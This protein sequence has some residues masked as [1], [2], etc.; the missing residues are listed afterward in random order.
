M[1]P[2]STAKV[3]FLGAGA[4]ISAGYP[5]TSELLQSILAD[6]SASPEVSSIGSLLGF[7]NP[8]IPLSYLDL[9]AHA[10]NEAPMHWLREEI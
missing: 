2:R 6:A 8:E 10:A 3:L 7:P 4:S 9:W 1:T 5:P